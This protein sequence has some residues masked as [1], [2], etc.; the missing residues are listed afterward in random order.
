MIALLGVF[1]IGGLV[2]AYSGDA[3]NIVIEGDYIEAPGGENL[4]EEML[5]ASGTRFPYGVSADTTSPIAGEV[6]GTTLKITD[7]ILY[8]ETASTITAATTVTAA[9]SGTTFYMDFTAGATST[10]PAVQAGLVYRFVVSDN[11]ATS[12][13]V[14]ASTEGDNIEGALIVAG[15]VVDCDAEDKIKIVADG[16]N[17]GDYV[18][19]RSDGVKWFLGD[20][21]ALTGSKMTCEDDA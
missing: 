15:A 17:L 8:Q 9:Q 16:E 2:T 14:I 6:R 3:P 11:F 19:F 4:G 5:G 20:S 12:D 13:M 7:G 1:A 21:G 10:L 18:E